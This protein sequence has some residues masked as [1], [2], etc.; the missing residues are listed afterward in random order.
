MK[1]SLWILL[2][3]VGLGLVSCGEGEELVDGSTDSEKTEERLLDNEEIKRHVEAQL[4]ILPTENY[5]IQ[6]FEEHLDTDE[7][8][9]KVIAVNL[10]DRAIKEADASGQRE[11]REKMGY[12]GQFNYI[13]YI[14][15]KTQTIT[16]GIAVPSSPP[17]KLNVSF[18]YLTSPTHKDII[19]DFRIRR[20]EFRQFYSIRQRVPIQVSETELF[21]NL[22][23][24]EFE[25]FYVELEEIPGQPWL[26]I[27]VYEGEFTNPTI[28]KLE[29]TYK[30]TPEIKKGGKLIRRWYFSEKHLKYYVR[31]DEL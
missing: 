29:D 17:F 9:D 22:G 12:T 3:F 28:E 21:F 14:D 18:D 2:F 27:A 7:K 6:I 8:I 15:G 16:S 30:V 26:S 25:A 19:V 20:S 31:N 4:K 24:D 5:D 23:D 1:I 10:L 11:Y 13:F